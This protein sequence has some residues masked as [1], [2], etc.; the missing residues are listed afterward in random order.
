MQLIDLY[1]LWKFTRFDGKERQS[2]LNKVHPHELLIYSGLICQEW[3]VDA[4]VRPSYQIGMPRPR[5]FDREEALGRAMKVLWARGYAATS[6]EDLLEAMRIGRQSFYNTFGDKRRIYFEALATYQK[7]TG[8]AHLKRLNGPVSSFQGIRNLLRGLISDDEDERALGCMGVGSVA[9]FGTA[10]PELV[11]LRAKPGPALRAQL[12][13]RL[14]E[15]QANGEID[16][17]LDAQET[18]S[19][20]LMAMNGLQVAARG[21]GDAKSLRKMAQFVVNRL[22]PR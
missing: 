20:V 15:G 7:R 12:V 3:P 18:A 17:R 2:N 21:G 14:R 4:V 13:A 8:A 6:T 5:E 11:A 19:F 10:D 16:S 22:R 9:E 1:H